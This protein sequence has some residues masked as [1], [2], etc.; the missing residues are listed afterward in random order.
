VHEHPYG[1][2]LI[3]ESGSITFTVNGGKRVVFLQPGDRLEL[4]PH[5]PHSAV[6]GPDGVVCVETH[7]SATRPN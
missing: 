4:A 1:K 5:T 3:V 7:R 2:I 6:V